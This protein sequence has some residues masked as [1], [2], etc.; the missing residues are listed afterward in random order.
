M[1]CIILC[2]I[3]LGFGLLAMNEAI[4]EMKGGDK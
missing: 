1:I 3:G 2:F 4:L